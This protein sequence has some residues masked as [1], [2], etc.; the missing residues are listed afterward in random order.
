MGARMTYH[1]LGYHK[2]V[3]MIPKCTIE[4]FSHLELLHDDVFVL[5]IM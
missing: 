3:T 1:S 2:F 5:I 4:G